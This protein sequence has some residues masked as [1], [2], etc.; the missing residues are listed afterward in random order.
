[1]TSSEHHT[2]ESFQVKLDVRKFDGSLSVV[3]DDVPGLHVRGET[4]EAVRKK[5]IGAIQALYW[6]NEKV[7][8]DVGPTDDPAVLRVRRQDS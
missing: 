5:A 3:S 8:V 7:R 2:S 4:E 1:M 6:F